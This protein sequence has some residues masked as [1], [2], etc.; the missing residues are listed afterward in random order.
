MFFSRLSAVYLLTFFTHLF[1]HSMDN[2]INLPVDSFKTIHINGKPTQMLSLQYENFPLYVCY[3]AQ[4]ANDAS[5]Q[6]FQNK[7]QPEQIA[8]TYWKLSKNK[9]F[10]KGHILDEDIFHRFEKIKQKSEQILTA[11]EIELLEAL[12]LLS[13]PPLPE[14]SQIKDQNTA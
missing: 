10:Q 14:S 2:T 3:T 6:A 8:V 11:P 1:I 13:N 7:E 12:Y 5:I 9:K 4:L